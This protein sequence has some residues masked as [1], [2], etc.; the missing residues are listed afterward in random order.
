VKNPDGK[1]VVHHSDPSQLIYLSQAF[2]AHLHEVLETE[3][4]AILA[5]P[6]GHLG[7]EEQCDD[8]PLEMSD[9]DGD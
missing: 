2:D 4:L 5:F 3:L 6:D 8:P 1:S 7:G 9:I